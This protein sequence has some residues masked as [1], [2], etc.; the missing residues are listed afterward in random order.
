[1]F[2][3][4]HVIIMLEKEHNLKLFSFSNSWLF[5]ISIFFQTEEKHIQVFILL[6]NVLIR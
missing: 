4:H 5:W 2:S 6:M 3:I 1:M